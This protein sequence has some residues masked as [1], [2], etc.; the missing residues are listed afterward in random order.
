MDLRPDYIALL[1]LFRSHEVEFIIV[2]AYALALHGAPRNTGDIDILI[3]PELTNALRVLTALEQFGFASL[4][5]RTEDFTTPG[6]VIQLGRVPVRVD[7]L[8]SITGVTWEEADAGKV[9][10]Q[11]SGVPLFFLG[12]EQYVANKRATGRHRDLADLE[13]LGEDPGA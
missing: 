4:G 12:R 2:G 10:G 11:L 13:A 8:T 5:L 6:Q 3:K 1:G 7:L 9:S